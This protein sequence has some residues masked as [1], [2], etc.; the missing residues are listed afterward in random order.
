MAALRALPSLLVGGAGR[1]MASRALLNPVGA[2][3][4]VGAG[5]GTGW[6]YAGY[7]AMQGVGWIDPTQSFRD[8]MQTGAGRVWAGLTTGDTSNYDRS[9][10]DAQAAA[11]K[12][13]P[14]AA[15]PDPMAGLSNVMAGLQ[16]T[17][18]RSMAGLTH[19]PRGQMSQF[20]QNIPSM[21]SGAYGAG[22]NYLQGAIQEGQTNRGTWATGLDKQLGDPMRFQ[23]SQAQ[24]ELGKAR[25][26]LKEKRDGVDNSPAL[27]ALNEMIALLKN[28]NSNTAAIPNKLDQVSKSVSDGAA[29][30]VGYA[31][32]AMAQESALTLLRSPA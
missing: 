29:R 31:V 25:A 8:R 9:V 32:H 15:L 10:L 17:L 5:I 4:A 23:V 11:A 16:S 22:A 26:I 28:G 13:A 3:T 30:T 21:A 6:G 24:D 1:G 12:A 14:N 19:P 27:K 20:V 2:M 18:S 7:K